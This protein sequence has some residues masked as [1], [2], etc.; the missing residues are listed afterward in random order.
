MQ[1]TINFLSIIDTK[2]KR[3]HTHAPAKHTQ[4]LKDRLYLKRNSKYPYAKAIDFT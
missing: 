1:E 4:S 3:S 2:I